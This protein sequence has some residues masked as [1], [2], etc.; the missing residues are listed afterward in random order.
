[1][2]PEFHNSRDIAPGHRRQSGDDSLIPMINIVF[3]L[4]IFFM[5]AGQIKIS[6]NPAVLLP[7]SALGDTAKEQPWKIEVD[8]KNRLALNGTPV[9]IAQLD[10][11]LGELDPASARISLLA[12]KRLTARQLDEILSLIRARGIARVSLFSDGMASDGQENP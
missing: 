4:L 9:D 12:D 3:L 8:R 2:L 1:M 6:A 7:Y 10:S 5:V 11:A